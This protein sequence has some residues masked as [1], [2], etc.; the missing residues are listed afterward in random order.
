MSDVSDQETVA[1]HGQQT[2][3]A[4]QEQS[5]FLQTKMAEIEECDHAN[6]CH[7]KKAAATAAGYS[8][9]EDYVAMQEALAAAEANGFSTVNDYLA[10]LR[11]SRRR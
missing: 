7:V 1:K 9:V 10:S 3:V 11:K 2:A 5:E 8:R 4:V 6:C